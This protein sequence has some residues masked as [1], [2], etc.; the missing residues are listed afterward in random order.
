MMPG[1]YAFPPYGWL[2]IQL[3]KN[4]GLLSYLFHKK[5][6]WRAVMVG[7]HVE[8]AYPSLQYV[9]GLEMA[10][11]PD[12]KPETFCH[13]IE[14]HAAEMDVITLH[15]FFPQYA[16][17]V[18]TYRA[19]RPDGKIYLELDP[20]I[21]YESRIDWSKPEPL[22]FLQA[23]DV[24]GAS[25]RAMQQHL[26]QAWPAVIDFLPNGFYD[27]TGKFRPMT[28]ADFAAKENIILTVARI[29]TAQKQNETL[30][31]AFAQGVA[32]G[33]LDG[34]RLELVGT[35][36]D[37]FHTY[38]RQLAVRYPGILRRISLPGMIF[39]KA[40]L[41]RHYRR[42]KIFALTSTFE[43]GGPNVVAEALW[44]GCAMVTSKVDAWEDFIDS[45]RC[46]RAFPIGDIPALAELLA[47]LTG[48]E[49]ALASY[50]RHAVRYGARTQDFLKIVDEFYYL[51]Y[52]RR[53]DA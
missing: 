25:C 29:G 46:G 35:V 20:N 26:A 17:L 21:F 10:F 32:R 34:W 45:G 3:T 1:I 14:A 39:D 24:I 37:S 40:E 13:Y 53:P 49:A 2:D 51:L 31:E 19:L 47:D 6:G 5:Y 27:Y 22:A 18:R 16:P 42:A 12:G 30:C 36:K 52:Q 50:G 7:P 23:C 15:G 43:G 8:K 41:Y 9:P 4:C 11:L 28:D 48:D 44:H 38:L 33:A